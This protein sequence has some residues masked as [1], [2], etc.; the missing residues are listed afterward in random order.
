MQEVRKFLLRDRDYNNKIFGLLSYNI[1][2]KKF[3]LEIKQGYNIREYPPIVKE[4]LERGYK[5]LP[6]NYMKMW[7]KERII[8][9]NR[10]NIIDILRAAG[11]KEYDE[12]G[13]LMYTG[14]RCCQDEM[15]LEEVP[16]TTQLSEI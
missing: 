16:N 4:A 8:P 6:D 10:Q 1:R 12:F 2:L 11:L 15:Y 13:M 9:P 3:R 5:E 14:G 7:V